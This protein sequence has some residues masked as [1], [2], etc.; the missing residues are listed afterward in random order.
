MQTPP[1]TLFA[2]VIQALA[3]LHQEHHQALLDLQKEQ[4]KRFQLLLQAQTDDRELFRGWITHQGHSE[5]APSAVGPSA[6][7][8]LHKMGPQDDPEAFL[9]LFER[10][11]EVSGW[12]R[13]SWAARLIPLLSGEA[14]LAAQQLPVQN[15][16]SY[17]DL[18]KAILQRVGLTR[19]QQRQ[20]FRS[21]ELGDGGQPFVFAQR[22]RDACRKWLLD[23]DGDVDTIVERVVL[24]QFVG[25]LPTETAQWVQ[26]HRPASLS[27]AVQLA[28]DHMAACRGVGE[29]QNSPLSFFPV[30][31]SRP[32]PQAAAQARG[33]PGSR[34][35]PNVKATLRRGEA[36]GTSTSSP[37]IPASSRQSLGLLPA[38]G[39]AGRPGPACWRCGDPGHLIKRCPVMEV[40]AVI[41]IPDA[42]RAALDQAGLYQ[43]P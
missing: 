11:A 7:L 15:L 17:A 43:I 2:D 9:E 26:C 42:P 24:E 36:S 33:G 4:E 25:R 28:E 23:D 5:G 12:L 3:G 14:Q 20:R 19:E 37:F 22:L 30:P 1:T 35:L 6:P 41:R 16:R 40:G 13:D 34:F 18:R 39:A 32:V 29:P 10:S 27:Q 8:L 38:T 31:R 21:L